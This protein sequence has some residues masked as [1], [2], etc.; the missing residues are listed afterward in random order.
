MLSSSDSLC[1]CSH[2]STGFGI[3]SQNYIS[4]LLVFSDI[5]CIQEHFLQ[6]CGDKKSSNTN[7]LRKRFNNHDMFIV[8]AEKNNS[9][10]S[11]G[12]GKGGLATIWKRGLT[13]YVMKIECNNSRLQATKFDFPSGSLLVLN[14]YFPCD[15]RVNN[16]DDTEVLTLLADIKTAIGTSHC[17]HI[18]LCGDLNCHFERY[19]RYTNTVKD[20]LEDINF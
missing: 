17:H 3:S 18:L 11:R 10:I 5:L 15:P 20:F 16:F 12:R 4:S 13:K 9:Q 19:N 6:D 8:P 7:L 2:N 1:V 14:V